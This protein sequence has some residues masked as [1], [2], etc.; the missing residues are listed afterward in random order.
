[1]GSLRFQKV[2]FEPKH[3]SQRRPDPNNDG[4]WIWDLNGVKPLPYRL[5]EL[6]AASQ[7]ATIF[8]AEGEK[9]VDALRG[10][11]AVASCNSEG[12]GKGGKWPAAISRWFSGRDVVIIPDDDDVGREHARDVAARLKGV[13][14]R[15]RALVLPGSGKDPFDW[16]AAGGT[17]E[18]LN[19]LAE[20]AA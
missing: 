4:K 1:N 7:D 14:A 13:A 9:D 20:E 3:F 12:A 11:G 5:P 6:L 8:I 18:E 19:R 17:L 10:I 2:R 16:I 15:I